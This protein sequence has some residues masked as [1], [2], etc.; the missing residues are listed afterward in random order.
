MTFMNYKFVNMYAGRRKTSPDDLF[1]LYYGS[2]APKRE[3][4]ESPWEVELAK[5]MNEQLSE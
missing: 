5:I 2:K 1:K 4:A 3:A